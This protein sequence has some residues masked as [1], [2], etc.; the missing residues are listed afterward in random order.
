MWYPSSYVAANVREFTQRMKKK[1][2]AAETSFYRV[3]IP[4]MDQIN[5]KGVLKKMAAD[6]KKHF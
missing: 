3:K 1:L 4:W 2:E 6:K 5:N